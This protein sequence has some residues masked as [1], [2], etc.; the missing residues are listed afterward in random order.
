MLYHAAEEEIVVKDISH[1]LQKNIL[2]SSRL[3]KWT[4][5]F[6]S[7]ESSSLERSDLGQK[8]VR[9][10]PS[11]WQL[12]TEYLDIDDVRAFFSYF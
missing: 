11:L 6:C 3:E 8:P 12:G 7:P 4:G 2:Q 9:C 5:K 1:S 10:Q